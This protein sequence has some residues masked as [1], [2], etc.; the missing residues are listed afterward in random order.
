MFSVPIILYDIAQRSQKWPYFTIIYQFTRWNIIYW[1]K[2][3]QINPVDGPNPFFEVGDRKST[4]KTLKMVFLPIVL[5]SNLTYEFFTKNIVR[6]GFDHLPLVWYHQGCSVPP[7][8]ILRFGHYSKSRK[9]DLGDVP[10]IFFEVWDRKSG[11]NYPKNGLLSEC[12]VF[13]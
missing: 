8:R 4:E 11:Q 1:H 9:F 3:A 6:G 13:Q 2:I 12:L 5:I 7:R 10:N